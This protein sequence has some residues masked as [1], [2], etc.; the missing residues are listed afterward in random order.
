MVL[1][2]FPLTVRFK[3]TP[4]QFVPGSALICGQS[5]PGP[6]ASRLLCSTEA[7]F[8]AC[9]RD[10]CGPKEEGTTVSPVTLT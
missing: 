6:Q 4:A 9:R 8:D 7:R 5:Y 10:A 3:Q 2:R 1:F